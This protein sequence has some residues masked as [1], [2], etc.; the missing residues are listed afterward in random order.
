MKF[1]SIIAGLIL[2]ALLMPNVLIAGG[3]SVDAGL[4]P[5]EDKWIV[6][7]QVRYSQMSG[8]SSPMTSE[9]KMYGVPVMVAYGA[10]SFLT[11]MA[12]Q[13]FMSRDMTMMNNSFKDSGH[14]DFYMLAKYKAYR[15]NTPGHT[16]G[17][18][19]I[20]GLSLPTG[21]DKFT[22]D[23]YDLNLGLF[24]SGRKESWASDLNIVYGL[25]DISGKE[26]NGVK[27][28][29]EFSF[30][31]AAA[32]Q[33]PLSN[34]RAI[35]PVVELAFAKTMPDNTNNIDNPY[36]GE[37]VIYLSPGA[38]YALNYMIIEALAQI[39]ISQEQDGMQM[40]R[41]FGFIFGIRYL[42]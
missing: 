12:R 25:K 35:A 33:I 18:S 28:G 17:I 1:R 13:T 15:I 27:S 37:Y 4:T 6:R 21:D 26:P 41:D 32:K 2:S 22:S 9:M 20:V 8:E 3:I 19:P 29:D 30:N 38:K 14:S 31:L 39:P 40:R 16:I 42:F 23:T 24:F 7:A 5:A 10:R 36:T 34:F 11:V